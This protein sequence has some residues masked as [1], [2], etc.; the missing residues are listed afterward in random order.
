MIGFHKVRSQTQIAA[1]ARL[2]REIWTAHYTPIIGRAQ[3]DYMVQKFQSAPAVA[4]QV[5]EDYAY[6]LVTSD[7]QEVGYLAVVPDVDDGSLLLSKIYLLASQRGHGLGKEM[8]RFVE[9]L[10]RRQGLGMVWLTVNK[11]NAA[12]IAWYERMGFTNAGPIV[13]DIGG[14]FVM[15]DYKMEKTFD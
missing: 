10:C 2:A 9:D 6:Y 7:A 12:A 4:A 8:L 15:D 5:D 11:H 13:Q 1:V 14:G 3:V